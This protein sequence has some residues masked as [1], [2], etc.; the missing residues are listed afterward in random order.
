MRK[1]QCCTSA[2]L[3]FW[4]ELVSAPT[5]VASSWTQFYHIW[6]GLNSINKVMCR[7]KVLRVGRIINSILNIVGIAMLMHCQMQPHE[8]VF[9]PSAGEH[10]DIITWKV[11]L[12]TGSLRSESNSHQS[13]LLAKSHL[14]W[15]LWIFYVI[16][17]KLLNT[18]LICRC[19]GTPWRSCDVTVIAT[20]LWTWI[21]TRS[22]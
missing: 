11:F 9:L 1:L 18:Q 22:C 10:D 17:N 14:H 7:I 19:F 4:W 21:I 13:I 20:E 5:T 2:L 16:Q 3:S 12:V 6:V 15:L 8:M